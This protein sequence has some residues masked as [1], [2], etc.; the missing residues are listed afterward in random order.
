[1]KKIFTAIVSL[2]MCVCMLCACGEEAAVA[3]NSYNGILTKVKIGMPLT[4]IVTMQPDGVELYWEDDTTIWSVNTDTD[5]MG[6]LLALIPADDVYHYADDSIIT[7]NFKTKKGDDELY[8]KGYTEEVHCLLERSVAE[9][10]FENKTIELQKKHCTDGTT[11]AGTLVGT[12][13]V[14]MELVYNQK[15]SASSYDLVFSMTFTY[16]TV[17]DI[18]GYYATKFS[19]DITEKEVKGEVAIAT[20]SVE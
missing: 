4:K 8:L 7:Y 10:Y 3:E 13:D 15:I 19:I 18:T 5:L 17:D 20:P 14:D 16:D 12:E 9:E 11:A 2:V 1:M 6:E